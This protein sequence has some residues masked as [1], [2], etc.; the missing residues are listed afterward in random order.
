MKVDLYCQRLSTFSIMFL[1]LICRI[2]FFT[3]MMGRYILALL[4]RVS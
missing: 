1:A 3:V 4:S 2:E